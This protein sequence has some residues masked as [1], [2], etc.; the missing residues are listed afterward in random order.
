[1]WRRFRVRNGETTDNVWG[2]VGT[3]TEETVRGYSKREDDTSSDF[4]VVKGRTRKGTSFRKVRRGVGSLDRV[5]SGTLMCS[6]KGPI[7]STCR[8]IS[9]YK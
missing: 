3:E 6:T 5:S 7:G 2:W 4:V 1:M 8:K 9:G